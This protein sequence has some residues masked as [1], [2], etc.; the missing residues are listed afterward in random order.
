MS[1]IIKSKLEIILNAEFDDDDSD[2]ETLKYLVEQDL[3][4]SGYAI[5][6]IKLIKV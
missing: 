6:S 3:E 5:E 4:D 2:E 1:K